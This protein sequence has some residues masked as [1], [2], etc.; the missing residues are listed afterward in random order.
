MV[1]SSYLSSLQKYTNMNLGNICWECIKYGAD[2]QMPWGTQRYVILHPSAREKGNEALRKETYRV[3]RNRAG[4]A[5]KAPRQEWDSGEANKVWASGAFTWWVL[6]RD[7]YGHTLL[8]N[9]LKKDSFSVGPVTRP[10]LFFHSNFP[11][12]TPLPLGGVRVDAGHV[13]RPGG[14]PG[15]LRIHFIWV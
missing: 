12:V 9:F 14:G 7:Q 4:S 8:Q 10:S 13:C 6:P 2:F 5:V 15:E 1:L 11:H 3:G